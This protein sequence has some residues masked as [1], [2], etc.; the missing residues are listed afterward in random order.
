[1]IRVF[2]L[3]FTVLLLTGCASVNKEKA[4]KLSDGQ[5]VFLLC[6]FYHE[7]SYGEWHTIKRQEKI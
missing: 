2:I 4:G 7:D 5:L 3:I 1:M 6:S